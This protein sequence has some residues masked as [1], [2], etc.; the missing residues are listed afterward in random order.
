[1]TLSDRDADRRRRSI[2]RARASPALS[3]EWRAG[4]RAWRETRLRQPY[5]ARMRVLIAPDKFR[6]TLSAAEAA[7]AVATGWH[8]A[9]P[10]DE[11]DRAALASG[12]ACCLYGGSW[13]EQ[14]R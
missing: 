10:R 7:R 8:R 3:F 9:R 14:S 5:R 4:S 2:A 6:G 13:T 12:P 11:L 1:M